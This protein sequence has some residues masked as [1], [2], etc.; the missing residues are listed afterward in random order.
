MKQI[1]TIT[2]RRDHVANFD[3]AVNDALN[4]GWRL[5]KRFLSPMEAH[6]ESTMTYHP[7]WVAYLERDV[8]E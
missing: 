3:S 2:A 5:I 1:K 6:S 4:Q 8:L 7:I